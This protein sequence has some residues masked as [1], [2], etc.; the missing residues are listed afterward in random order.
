MLIKPIIF[1]LLLGILFVIHVK[2]L[3]FLIYFSRALYLGYC[4]GQNCG[5][6]AD[7]IRRDQKGYSQGKTCYVD[8]QCSGSKLS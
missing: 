6:C 1:N 7:D 4:S 5:P 8:D 3:L 2:F